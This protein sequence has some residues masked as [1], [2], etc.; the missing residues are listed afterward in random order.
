MTNGKICPPPDLYKPPRCRI[1]SKLALIKNYSTF[2]ASKSLERPC[3]M[4]KVYYYDAKNHLYILKTVG[5]KET[6]NFYYKI[7]NQIKHPS[8]KIL[9]QKIQLVV[10]FQVCTNR[11]EFNCFCIEPTTSNEQ[12]S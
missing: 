8:I 4:H 2:A 6:Q 1:S 9:S 5:K 10:F 3:I 7:N 12:T 11:D